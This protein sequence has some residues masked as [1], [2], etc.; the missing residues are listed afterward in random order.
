MQSDETRQIIDGRVESAVWNFIAATDVLSLRC[1]CVK[2][3]ID[4]GMDARREK[5]F[6]FFSEDKAAVLHIERL[7]YQLFYEV[8]IWLVSRS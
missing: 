2:R 5:R 3:S 8:H 7:Q 4:P 6:H 1:L